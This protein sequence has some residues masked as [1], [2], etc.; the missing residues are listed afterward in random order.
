LGNPGNQANAKA[1]LFTISFS[2]IIVPI[3][4]MLNISIEKIAII[5]LLVAVAT[6]IV[7]IFQSTSLDNG[8]TVLG[9]LQKLYYQPYIIINID[10][11]VVFI[12]GSWSKIVSRNT[13]DIKFDKIS[14]DFTL[15]ISMKSKGM[16]D[17]TVFCYPRILDDVMLNE[18]TIDNICTHL[19]EL[20]QSARDL[21][22]ITF[23]QNQGTISSDNR[24]NL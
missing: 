23:A 8:D 7:G 14:T 22:K 19:N 2:L 12:T 1:A 17:V 16:S 13:S 3:L 6:L 10:S 9:S 11:R 18:P 5:V 24:P 15:G 20:V 4:F 21:P